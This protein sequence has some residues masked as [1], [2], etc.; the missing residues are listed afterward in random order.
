MVYV[1]VASAFPGARPAE[2]PYDVASA[3]WYSQPLG[4]GGVKPDKTL[5]GETYQLE[6][7]VAARSGAST[8]FEVIIT[9][10]PAPPADWDVPLLRVMETGSGIS[11]AATPTT[12]P[13]P[14]GVRYRFQVRPPLQGF[15]PVSDTTNRTG[16][17]RYQLAF[18]PSRDVKLPPAMRR[19]G[20]FDGASVE[21]R[22]Q[23]APPQLP[24]AERV[25][26][27]RLEFR[28]TRSAGRVVNDE[29]VAGKRQELR[30]R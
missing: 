11:S 5:N 9:R 25:A 23:Q 28:N 20:T 19:A 26:G 13:I 12:S 30:R 22:M 6:R 7:F 14:G 2:M 15:I 27:R 3:A 24:I 17:E 29:K 1:P 10:S 18:M 4:S 8:V 16:A 21:T